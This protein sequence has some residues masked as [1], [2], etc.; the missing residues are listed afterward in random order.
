MGKYDGTMNLLFLV[1]YGCPAQDI[2]RHVL[3]GDKKQC[4][5]KTMVML[6]TQ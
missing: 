4:E 3:F 1:Y 5:N 2:L 6:S